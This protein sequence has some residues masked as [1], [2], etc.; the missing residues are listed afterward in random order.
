MG[1]Q[2]ISIRDRVDVKAHPTVVRLD[3]LDSADA[4][5]IAESFLLTPEVG[6]HLKV[7]RQLFKKGEG[8]GIFLIGHYGCGK[9]HFLAYLIQQLR[10]Q[11]FVS[12]V[13]PFTPY[14]WLI[15]VQITGLKILLRKS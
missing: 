4:K 12:P 7:L 1:E 13:R 15:S 3:D 14:R 8:C 5:W 2:T 10:G 9:S 6:N 11:S